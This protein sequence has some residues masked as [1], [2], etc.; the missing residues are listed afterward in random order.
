MMTKSYVMSLGRI[1]C[2]TWMQAIAADFTH[3]VVCVMVK[4]MNQSRCRLGW[5]THVGRR[6]HVLDEGQ[7]PL[8]GLSGP[9]KSIGSLGSG[10]CSKGIIQFLQVHPR[11]FATC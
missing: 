6:N 1:T 9:F 11:Y 3:S 10:K 8:F 7:D 2:I 5:L 4:L